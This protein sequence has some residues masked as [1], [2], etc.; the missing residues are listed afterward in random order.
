MAGVIRVAIVDDHPA[1]AEGLAAL[2]SV[3]PGLVVVG[4]AGSL[5]TATE[6]I[7][8][9]APDVAVVD[10]LIAGRPVGFDLLRR[11]NGG[12]GPAVILFSSFDASSFHARA[13]QLGARGFLAK[14]ARIGEVVAA[15]RVV[16]AGGT[17][18][19]AMTIDDARRAPRPPSGREVE[20]IAFV[21]AG[22]SNQEI[23]TRLGITE[24]SVESHLRRLFA[25]YGL[26]S[27][28]ELSM[29]AVQQG[30][31]DPL[32]LLADP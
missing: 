8:R 29:L 32:A 17:A 19:T 4:T 23:G 25:R 2:L 6:L 15:I 18:F 21:A 24:K 13:V 16:A 10:I 12:P 14:T 30:W 11:R 27:R 9:T 22:R 31:V 26:A 3:Q 7:E 5:A 20:V 1:T 28:T